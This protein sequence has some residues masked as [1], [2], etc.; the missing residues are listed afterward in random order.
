MA[1]VVAPH[2]CLDEEGVAWL[3]GTQTKVIE[4]VLCQQANGL[5]PEEIHDGL[6]HLSVERIRAALAYYERHRDELEAD[7]ARRQEWAEEFRKTQRPGPT[8]AELLA[9]LRESR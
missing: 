2:I 8:R 7:I 6:P 9:R 4:V 5:T 3:E 1:T